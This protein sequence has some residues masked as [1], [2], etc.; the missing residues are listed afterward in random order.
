M[1][2]DWTASMVEARF[3]EAAFTLRRLPDTRVPGYFNTWPAIV[4]SVHEAFGY[5]RARMPRIAPTPQSIS[6]MEETFTWLTWLAPDDARIVWMRAEG[7]PWKPICC[8]VGLSRQHAWRRWV[9]ALMTVSNRLSAASKRTKPKPNLI[10]IAANHRIR[11]SESR[12]NTETN[13]TIR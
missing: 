10:G 4:R 8:R 13:R 6:R 12:V 9:A 7:S 2:E 1:A 5:E 11:G 3:E